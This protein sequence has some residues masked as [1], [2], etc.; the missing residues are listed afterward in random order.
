MA[1]Q[2]KFEQRQGMHSII[3]AELTCIFDSC[4]YGMP[5][6]Q[7]LDDRNTLIGYWN[8]KGETENENYRRTRNATSLDGLARLGA[9]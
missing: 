6:Y 5:R 9:I 8:N 3:R 2:T 4:G 1:R 7:Y